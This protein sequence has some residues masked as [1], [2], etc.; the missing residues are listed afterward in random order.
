VVL[1]DPA[2][3]FDSCTSNHTVHDRD[4]FETFVGKKTITE[5]FNGVL[6]E[7]PVAATSS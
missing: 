6:V 4:V 3:Y 2:F 1:K 5:G 7:V